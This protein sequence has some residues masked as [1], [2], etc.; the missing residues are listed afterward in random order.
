MSNENL[1]PVNLE[2]MTTR[3]DVVYRADGVSIEPHFCRSWDSDG[4]CYGT[5]PNHGLSAAE[6]CDE[7]AEWHEQQAKM[8]RDR[9]HPDLASYGNQNN[10]D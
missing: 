9:T 7:V 10:D 4:G 1:K 3:F 5:N 8:W 2:T 6:A